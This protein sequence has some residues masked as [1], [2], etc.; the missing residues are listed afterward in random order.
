MTACRKPLILLGV[1]GGIAAYKAVDVASRLLKRGFDVRV[2]MTESATHF[3][4]PTTFQAVLGKPVIT[5]MFSS[6]QA[7]EKNE[8]YPHLYPAQEADMFVLLPATADMLAQITTG[9]AGNVVSGSVLGLRQDCK[10]IFCPAMNTHMWQQLVVKDNVQAL[11]QRGWIQVG[12]DDGVLACGSRGEGRMSQPEV[13]EQAVVHQLEAPQTLRDQT[14]LILSG[15]THEHFDPVR[16]I[17]NRSSGKMGRALA[18]EAAARGAVVEFVTGP[19]ATEMIP[20][21]PS[22]YIHHVTSANDMLASASSFF[23]S[24]SITIFAAAVA[25]YMPAERESTKRAKSA[26]D[27][28]LTL[29]PTPDIA[30]TL[31]KIKQTGQITVGF[32]LQDQHAEVHAKEKLKMKHLDALILNTLDAMGADGAHYRF[33]ASHMP[34]FIDWGALSKPA[35]ARLLFDH[36]K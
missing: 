26:A 7:S 31:S 23:P 21:H 15:P 27:L 36:I 35:C 33:M 34:G 5:S 16:F 3:I 6:P 2:V 20:D 9:A 11:L 4:T 14:V 25:D 28:T 12:P 30:A 13:I 10:K 8:I 24:A 32:A 18:L 17:G 29:L 22:V 19:V 1:C